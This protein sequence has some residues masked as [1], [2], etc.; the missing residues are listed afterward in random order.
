MPLNPS[1]FPERT[2]AATGTAPESVSV[3]AAVPARL[4]ALP[5][6]AASRAPQAP[7]AGGSAAGCPPPVPGTAWVLE[8]PPGLKTLSLNGRLHWSEQRRRAAAIRKAAWAMALQQHVPALGR[9]SVIVEYQPPDKRH[10]DADNIPAVMGKHAID[11]LVAA[12]VIPDD[13]AGRYVASI[14]YRIGPVYPKGRLVLRIA[15]VPPEPELPQIGTC[16]D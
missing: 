11:G 12:G 2:A 4:A 8:L 5:P 10:R 7:G 6:E 14:A 1:R 13:E 15:Q 9:I 16:H 3:A